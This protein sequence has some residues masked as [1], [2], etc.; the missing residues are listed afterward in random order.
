M[1]ESGSG[2]PRCMHR[3]KRPGGIPLARGV[4]MLFTGVGLGWV[5]LAFGYPALLLV[6][7]LI[8]G[9]LEL[10]Y[11]FLDLW[12]PREDVAAPLSTEEMAHRDPRTPSE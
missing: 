7:A 8:T 2:Y 6:P 1:N 5:L 10:N 3:K 11:R 4:L 9:L 12:W